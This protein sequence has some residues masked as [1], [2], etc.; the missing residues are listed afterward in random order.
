MSIINALK[1]VGNTLLS[2]FTFFTIIGGA[3][4][5]TLTLVNPVNLWWSIAPIETPFGIV[6]Y[7]SVMTYLEYV[8]ANYYY[9]LGISVTTLLLGLIVHIRSFK[10][11]K[12]IIKAAPMAILKS[13]LYI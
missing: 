5:L 11:I 9:A 1:K 2:L 7:S 3:F 13:P 10:Q 8:Q 6:T 4:G 12:D